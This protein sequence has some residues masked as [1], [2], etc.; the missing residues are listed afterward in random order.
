MLIDSYEVEFQSPRCQHPGSDELFAKVRVMTDLADLIPYVNAVVRGEYIPGIPVLTWKAGAHKYALR[1]REIAVNNL[2]DRESGLEEIRH[3][4]D[5]L[6]DVWE[7]RAEITPDYAAREKPA[8]LDVFKL[9][10]RTN[11]KKCGL[12]SCMGYA[13]E[14]VAGNKSLDDC[15]PLLEAE[16]GEARRRLADM[17][18]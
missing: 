13:G 7:R 16:N 17:G 14:L 9:L 3:I 5:W 11:C 10:P 15:E 8:I 4:V 12:P 2:L 18:L 6:N 1:P